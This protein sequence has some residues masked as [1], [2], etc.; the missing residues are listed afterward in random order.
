MSNHTS[1]R[2]FIVLFILSLSLLIASCGGGGSD[3]DSIQGVSASDSDS[4]VSIDASTVAGDAT[5]KSKVSASK[6]DDLVL[7]QLWNFGDGTTAETINPNS[8]VTH[9]YTEDGTYTVS[10]TANLNLVE[11]KLTQS[12]LRLEQVLLQ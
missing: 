9:T 3:N 8:S 7:S 5:V 4:L 6:S 2:S 10:V 12:K 11:R 1:R